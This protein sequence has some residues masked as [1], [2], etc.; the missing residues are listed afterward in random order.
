MGLELRVSHLQTYMSTPSIAL[1]ANVYQDVLALRGLLETGAR[2]FDNIFLVHAGPNGTYSTDGT[3]ELAH[4]FGATIVFDDIARGFGAIRTRALHDCGCEWGFIMD[5][6]ERF[7]PE[8]PVIRCEGT[9]RYPEV[10]KPD[11]KV[12]HTNE[13]CDQGRYLKELIARP[14]VLAV[15]SQRRHWADFSM[16]RA[17]ENWE[18][19]HDWQLR[20]VKNIPEI[21][22]VPETKMHEKLRDVR[23]G[24][25]PVFAQEDNVRGPYHDHFHM[26]F[27][28]TQPG[29]KEFNESNYQRMDR[30]EPV[31]AR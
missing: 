17:M 13:I 1:C 24:R 28:M 30:N 27:R 16:K 7:F 9:D 6:D 26:F 21:Q 19:I 29:H 25:D 8:I 10:L 12:T 31:V 2:Y 14:G 5:A 4:Q 20:I 3:I 11:L 15:R 18:H 22:Y 23:T